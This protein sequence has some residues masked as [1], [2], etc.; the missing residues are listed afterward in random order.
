MKK[1][2]ITLYIDLLFCLI[3]I[4]LAIMLLPVDRWIVHNT[5]FLMTLIAYLYTLY[6]VYRTVC[7]P[8]LF[9]Q[10]KYLRIILILV[11]LVIVTQLLTYFPIPTDTIPTDA[12]QMEARMNM[13]RQTIWFFSL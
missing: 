2:R 3:I 13:R 11:I 1:K 9:I 6:F 7:L 10:K 12:R 8:K 4:P 5:A